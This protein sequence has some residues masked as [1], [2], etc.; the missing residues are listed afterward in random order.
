MYASAFAEE[1]STI[2]L[3]F[4]HF[5]APGD[6]MEVYVI[7]KNMEVA[8]SIDNYTSTGTWQIVTTNTTLGSGDTVWN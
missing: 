6:V 5:I 3:Q 4:K 2:S 7:N 1:G 8:I